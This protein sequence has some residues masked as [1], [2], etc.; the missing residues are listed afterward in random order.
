MRK[1]RV[2]SALE[3]AISNI[4]AQELNDPRLG[5]VTITGVEV[6]PDIKN[7]FV[8]FS[9][10]HDKKEALKALERAKGYIRSG[11]ARRVRLR[12]I[13]E[14]F[15]RIDDTYEKGKRIDELFEKI[16]PENKEE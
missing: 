7:A 14:L 9:S 12:T 15:F 8:Y 5:L 2:A 1:D 16:R 6:S 10:L 3:R 11:L 4:I 13:P